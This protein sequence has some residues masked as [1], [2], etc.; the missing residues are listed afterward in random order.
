MSLHCS[1]RLVSTK[2]DGS[3]N[4]SSNGSS[5][6]SDHPEYQSSLKRRAIQGS[7]WTLVGYGSAQIFRL[8]GNLILTRL[9][10][11]DA[12]GLM[13]LVQTFLTGLQLFSDFGVFP[14]I[15]H[16]KRGEDANFLNTAW[17]LQSIRGV[18][19]W[20]GACLLAAPI[21]QFYKE[22][23]LLQLLPVTGLTAIMGGVVSTKLAI[24]NRQ[25]ALKQLTILE[26]TTAF[27]SLLVTAVL[28]WIYR[29]VWALVIGN[30]VSTLLKTVASHWWL[31]GEPNQF[32]W[33]RSALKEIQQFGRWIFI[34]SMVGFFSLQSDRLILGRLLD[35]RFLG[36]YTIALSLSSLVEQ[37]VEQ[38]NG[39]V[40][41]PSY[42]ELIRE[43]PEALYRHLRS[44]RMIL[45]LL[46]AAF[47]LGFVLGGTSLINVLYDD[48][49]QEAGWILR[50]LSIGFLGRVLSTTYGDVLMARG[51]TFATMTL[52]LT[53]TCIQ[54]SMILLGYFLSDYQG[55]IVG[56]AA[57]DWITYIAY[58]FCFAKLSLWQP[59]LDVPAIALA[60]GLSAIVYF[61]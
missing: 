34:S 21:A 5:D 35:V 6:A 59:E 45:L 48:R 11:P 14:N 36:I 4:G 39:K 49:Y 42:A 31:Q 54:V 13:A 10:T 41:F 50:V 26:I 38:V 56:L 18:L 17:T 22:P 53:G 16:S 37:V 20:I 57:T 25:L 3:N 2:S 30:L 47:C 28:A 55:I 15:V 44:A 58:A 8:G 7:L 61:A 60:A 19:L 46:S 27:L 33:D 51:M 9:L 43:R 1:G 29:S 32:C 12:F 24:A 40:L 23:L 52:T